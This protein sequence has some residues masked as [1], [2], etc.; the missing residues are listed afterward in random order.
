MSTKTSIKRVALIAVSA[1]GFG[2]MSVVPSNA[3]VPT[4]FEFITAESISADKDTAVTVAGASNY[5]EIRSKA[6]VAGGSARVDVVGGTFVNIEEETDDNTNWAAPAVTYNA[7]ASSAFIASGDLKGPDAGDDTLTLRVSTP[8]AGSITIK[9]YSITVTNGVATDTLTDTLTVTVNATA[10]AGIVSASTSTSLI[11]KDATGSGDFNAITDDAVLKASG[12]GTLR[13]V[14]KVTARDANSVLLPNGKTV[15][16]AISGPGLLGGSTAD[17]DTYANSSKSETVTLA[18]GS[19]VAYFGVYSDGTAGVATITITSGTTT[20]ATESVTF[21]GAVASLAFTP[22]LY[23]IVDTANGTAQTDTDAL[24]GYITA[25]DSAGNT[26]PVAAAA[27]TV[28]SLSEKTAQ[29]ITDA[30]AVDLNADRTLPTGAVLLSGLAS[31][32]VVDP[33]ATKTGTK[34]ITVTHTATSVAI[35]V[36]FVVSLEGATTVVVTPD[37]SI[38]APGEKITLTVLAKDAGGNVVPDKDNA[39]AYSIST[40]TFQNATLPTS[41]DFVNGSQTI[42]LFAPN[43]PVA[44]FTISTKLVDNGAWVTDLDDTT[45]STK[46][47]V[48]ADTSAA[49]AAAEAA[50]E[51]T[52]AANQAYEAAV[53]ATETAE[54]AVA[55]AE[56]AKVAADA[57]TAAVEALATQVSTMIAELKAQLTALAKT[58]AKILRKV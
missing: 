2:L 28:S 42:S 46:V 27:L 37:K 47:A 10:T 7:A 12:A 32:I 29:A 57:A 4:N 1:L 26:V 19:G 11:D 24:V 54:A 55:A 43:A 52:D 45:I 51:A 58:V 21:Y 13:A 38:Y 8:T 31:V 33:T 39:G 48:V 56:D 44:E 14:I 36:S 18:A 53:V 6:D 50:V 15:T 34:T 17:I 49:D 40:N 25:K 35:K 30:A 20:L 41:A 23:S 9:V 5:V 3:V 16:A 22:T